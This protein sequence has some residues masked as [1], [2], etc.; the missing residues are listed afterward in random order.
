MGRH[1]GAWVGGLTKDS[2]AEGLSELG[3]GVVPVETPVTNPVATA[4][5]S[6]ISLQA[7]LQLQQHDSTMRLSQSPVPRHPGHC[8]CILSP[9]PQ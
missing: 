3:P 6:S 8:C 2:S 4:H 5:C 1:M 7:R 9:W